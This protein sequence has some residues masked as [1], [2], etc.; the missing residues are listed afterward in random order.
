MWHQGVGHAV[1]ASLSSLATSV[2]VLWGG[3]GQIATKTLTEEFL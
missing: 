3:A 1:S 2:Y